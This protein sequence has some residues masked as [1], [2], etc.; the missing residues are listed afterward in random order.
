[1]SRRDGAFIRAQRLHQI[2]QK[3]AQAMPE[4]ADYERVLDWIEFTIGLSRPRAKEYLDKVIRVHGWTVK[5]GV[6]KPA[7]EEAAGE[8]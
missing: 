1:M 4:G 2:A 6:I 3:V 5:N 8:A 7:E